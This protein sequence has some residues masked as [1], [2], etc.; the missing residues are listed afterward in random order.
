M[1]LLGIDYGDKYTGLAISDAKP[2]LAVAKDIV[3]GK[4]RQDLSKYI[5]EIITQEGIDVVVV[6]MPLGLDGQPTQQTKKTAKFVEW[7][8]TV[9]SVPVEVMDERMTT[10]AFRAEHKGSARPQRDD[11]QAARILLQNYIDRHYDNQE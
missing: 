8:R 3:Y 10:G 4:T 11:A 9:L 6:G 7:L 2:S 5:Q 1:R